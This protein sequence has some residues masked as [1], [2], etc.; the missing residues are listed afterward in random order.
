VVQD[1]FEIPPPCLFGLEVF[2][3]FLKPAPAFFPPYWGAPFQTFF[4]G[5]LSPFSTP[6]P[7]PPPILLPLFFPPPPK[8]SPLRTVQV[9]PYSVSICVFFRYFFP[10]Q[11]FYPLEKDT[12]P[13]CLSVLVLSADFS[14]F[15]FSQLLPH[16][17][18]SRTQC[19]PLALQVLPSSP[20][21]EVFLHNFF[22][23]STP[24]FPPNVSPIFPLPVRVQFKTF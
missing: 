22:L 12:R 4:S 20:F 15:L 11:P 19:W 23:N 24:S 6:I 17:Y 7:H 14:N 13:L 16:P 8:K 21:Y 9:S 2:T 3:I 1:S 18:G 10:L 5:P